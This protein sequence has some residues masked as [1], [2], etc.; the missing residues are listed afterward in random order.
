VSAPNPRKRKSAA[1]QSGRTVKTSVL[2]DG[3]LHARLSAAA[4][5]AGM[6]K[7]AYI[8]EAIRVAT[9]SIVLFDRSKQPDRVKPD[10]RPDS[11]TKI[12]SNAEEAA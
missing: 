12:S 11:A 6:D 9:R 2:L 3:E 10:D 1:P 5:M 7:N 8:V 4:A